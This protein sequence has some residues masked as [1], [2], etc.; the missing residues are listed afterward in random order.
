MKGR[1]EQLTVFAVVLV[2]ALAGSVVNAGLDEG[3]VGHWE[4]DET[5]GTTVSDSS[6]NGHNGTLM[7]GLSFDSNSV[8]GVIGKA[9][10]LTGAKGASIHA[11]SVS[12][13]TSAFTISLWF[14][15]DSD[16]DSS[17]NKWYLMFWGGDPDTS[18]N[19]PLYEFNEDKRGTI[20]LCIG[21]AGK[22]QYKLETKTNSWKA[23]TWYHLVATFD[24]A[25]VKLYVNGALED[26]AN[27]PGTHYASSKVCF[28]SKYNGERPFKG[29]LDDIRIYSQSL[30]ADEIGQLYRLSP[31]PRIFWDI[32]E[33]AEAILNEQEPQEAVV[34]LEEKIA[35]IEQWKEKNPGKYVFGTEGLVLALLLRLAAAKEAAGFPSKDVDAAYE[36]PIELGIRYS[37]I[38]GK[39]PERMVGQ[40]DPLARVVRHIFKDCEAKKNWP[41]AQR[42]LDTLFAGVKNPGAWA[43]FVESCLDDKTN[44]WAQEYSKYLDG[45]PR[46]KFGRDCLVAETALVAYWKLDETSGTIVHDSS[47]NGHHGT[48]KAGL[49]FD[50]NSVE[51]VIDK[52]LHL[53]GAEGASIHADS[54]SVPTSAFTISLWFNPDSHQDS[55]GNKW[56][57]MSWGGD[58][59]TSGNKPLYEF[60]EDER[61]TIRLCIGIVGKEQYKLE[62]KTNSWKA[63][64]SPLLTAPT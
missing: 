34:F 46:L 63:T 53:T 18:G 49:S 3:L 25:D 2:T 10:H 42:L 30:S 7:G 39:K 62:T 58:P 52:A 40:S 20:R 4:L 57:L 28:G 1:I 19:K 45:K 41:R 23:F 56:Y 55:S 44:R 60:N 38:E 48:L 15:P 9:L 31:V 11:D 64:W 27:Q 6:G 47:G 17:G 50:S 12:V 51:G 54:V 32:V 13:P 33:K 43:I 5:S 36:R 14:N 61:G 29:R 24:G 21:I 59:D 16:Q 22:E 26:S 37:S 35:G 8:E